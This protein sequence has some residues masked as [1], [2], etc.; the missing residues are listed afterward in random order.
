MGTLGR[1]VVDGY[2]AGGGCTSLHVGR[3][4]GVDWLARGRLG[5]WWIGIGGVW[6]E[7]GWI[8]GE[9]ADSW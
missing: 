4:W 7:G 8:G 1:R 5:E 2:W 6:V 9:R 3:G